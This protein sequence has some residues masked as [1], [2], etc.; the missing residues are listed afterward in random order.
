MTGS[1]SLAIVAV[2]LGA[3]AILPGSLGVLML[4]H[5]IAA[6]ASGARFVYGQSFWLLMI[7]VIAMAAA[8][9][10]AVANQS[11]SLVLWGAVVAYLGV[12]VFGFF[13]HVRLNFRPV[14]KPSF[15]SVDEAIEKFGPAEEV[16]GVIDDVGT[17][18][19]FVARLARRPHIV[20]QPEGNAP[21]FITHC[22]LSHSS[23]AYAMQD[24]F[25]QPDIIVTAVLA[26]NMVFYERS[27]KCAVIQ[28]ENGAHDPDLPLM[29]VPTV[30]VSLKTWQSLY[31]DSKV[32]IRDREWRDTF[33]L[34]LLARADVIDPDSPVMVYALQRPLDSRLPM[35]SYVL[36]VQIGEENKTYPVSLFD[37][38]Q[39]IEDEIGGRPL[40]ITA[41]NEGDYVQ[42]FDRRIEPGKVLTFKPAGMG[43]R[44]IDS[45]TGSEWLPTGQCSSGSYQGRQLQAVP[46]YNKIF[47]Y[48]W[49]DFFPGTE[50]YGDTEAES[51]EIAESAA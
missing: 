34:K 16:I 25:R 22:I 50:I 17:P 44:F 40:L 11:S 26:N 15:I 33:Y 4:T 21:F 20:Y 30:M 10:Q 3:V 38:Q 49:A 51:R 35:K 42:V 27:N 29:T 2:V 12:L 47:W 23:M 6:S 19:A 14:R 37:R 32:W 9:F 41:A 1:E 28:L 46:H 43:D 48:V 36:G 39:L 13:M 24:K 18:Y 7:S 45:E 31:P 8:L 5:K